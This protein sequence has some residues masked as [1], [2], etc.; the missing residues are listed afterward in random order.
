MRS[1]R[2]RLAV[3]LVDQGILSAAGFGLNLILIRSW[4]PATFGAYAVVI[5]ISTIAYSVQTSL[6]GT[7]LQS[8]RPLAVSR[9]DES[10]LLVTLWSANCLLMLCV[11]GLT[12][13]VIAAIWQ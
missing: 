10:E 9:K 1:M 2:K 7:Q 13:S 5:A 4:E 11:A 12:W 3:S 8:L 6:I